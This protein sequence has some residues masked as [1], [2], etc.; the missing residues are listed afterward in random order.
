MISVIDP[1]AEPT[2]FMFDASGKVAFLIIQHG[3][4]PEQLLDFD[5]NPVDGQTDDLIMITGFK[6]KKVKHEDD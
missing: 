4:Q 5:S 3:E 1:A 2:G 6:V